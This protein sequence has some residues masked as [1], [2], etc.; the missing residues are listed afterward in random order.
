M[1]AENW[2]QLRILGVTTIREPD[3]RWGNGS[4]FRANLRSRGGAG[5]H[6]DVTLPETF[7]A[8]DR[9]VTTTVTTGH[10]P[11]SP[12]E[13]LRRFWLAHVLRTPWAC[14]GS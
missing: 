14:G 4:K 10:S 12:S 13:N 3:L 1:K 6:G 9:P 7:R 2:F 5:V 11:L 8:S